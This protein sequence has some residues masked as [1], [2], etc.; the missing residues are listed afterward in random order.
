MSH[1]KLFISGLTTER[2]FEHIDRWSLDIKLYSVEKYTC[3]KIWSAGPPPP[4]NDLVSS[5][6][7]D[8]EISRLLL[9]D[10]LTRDIWNSL[11]MESNNYVYE[12]NENPNEI[13]RRSPSS[14]SLRFQCSKISIRGDSVLKPNANY[15]M[16]DIISLN[17]FFPLHL[18]TPKM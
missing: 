14:M 5:E 12:R 4:F 1:L 11:S 2:Q 9:A 6:T 16:R 7:F 3:F 15:V 13:S 10:M 8:Q 18:N 17:T